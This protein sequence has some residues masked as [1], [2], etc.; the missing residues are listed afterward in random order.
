[1]VFGAR[2]SDEGECWQSTRVS[3]RPCAHNIAS[4]ATISSSLH[5]NYWYAPQLLENSTAN[6]CRHGFQTHCLLCCHSLSTANF[7]FSHC[8]LFHILSSQWHQSKKSPTAVKT[9]Q[10]TARELS[11]PLPPHH[12]PVPP[13]LLH[14][15]MAPLRIRAALLHQACL[16]ATH[17]R[18]KLK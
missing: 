8:K 7:T 13:F 17:L 1:M 3:W 16:T 9:A 18:D 6:N 4:A 2:P 12:R 14:V 10:P 15:Q 5:W 11:L